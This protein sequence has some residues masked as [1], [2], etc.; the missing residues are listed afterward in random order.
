MLN[1]INMK[2]IMRYN[3][4]YQGNLFEKLYLYILNIFSNIVN[5]TKYYFIFY[6]K[7]TNLTKNYF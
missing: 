6:T 5:N 3:N 2:I 4:I 7:L 1:E